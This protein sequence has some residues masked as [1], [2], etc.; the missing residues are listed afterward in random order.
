MRLSEVSGSGQPFRQAGAAERKWHRQSRGDAER[1]RVL[2]GTSKPLASSMSQDVECDLISGGNCSIMQRIPPTA[3]FIGHAF[4]TTCLLFLLAM[5]QFL[6]PDP[7][8]Y[9]Q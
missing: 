5:S 7:K 1:E 9:G 3:A 6:V 4:Q 2:P 8:G